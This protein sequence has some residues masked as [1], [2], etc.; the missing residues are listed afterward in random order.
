MPK[1][2]LIAAAERGLG[3]G[4]AGQFF[5][6][7][8]SVTGTARAGVNAGD[9]EVLGADDPSRL[10]VA[11]IDVTDAGQI[12]PF[13]AELGERRIDVIYFNAGIYGPLHQ[14]VVKANDAE[15]A[16]IML[17]NTF[18]PIRLAHRL[19]LGQL[20]VDEKSNEITAVPKLLEL[21]PLKGCIVTADALNCQRAIAAKVVEQKA[22]YVLALKGNQRCLH[23][24]ARRFLAGRRRAACATHRTVDGEPWPHRDAGQPGVHRHRLVAGAARLA[25]VGGHRPSRPHPRGRH[26]GDQ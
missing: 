25:G 15:F 20:A 10:S 2:I 26:E 18:G 4:L 16:E 8:W 17:T 3:L 6:R 21:L 5:K 13:L 22:D 12:L 1:S 14:S 7:G 9:L 23:D 11:N 24:G 19:L